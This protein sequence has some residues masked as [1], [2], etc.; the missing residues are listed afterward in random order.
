M[1]KIASSVVK[2]LAGQWKCQVVSSGQHHYLT[3][4]PLRLD[5]QDQG[6][7]PYDLLTGSLA[8]CTMITLRMYAKHKGIDL[9]DFAVEADFHCDRDNQEWIERRIVFA[10]LPDAALQERILNVCGK[11]P[12][13]KTLL[14]SL[15]ITTHIVSK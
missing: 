7:S 8:A 5:G 11:T 15:S 2:P 9:G 3:D 12:V 6:P 13:T 10:N 14:R 4:E 1:N